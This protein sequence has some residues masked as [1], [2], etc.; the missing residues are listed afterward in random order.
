MNTLLENQK[1]LIHLFK[2]VNDES[3]EIQQIVTN[4]I[5]TN[6]LEIIFNKKYYL[7]TLNPEDSSQFNAILTELHLPLVYRSFRR[8]L[9]EAMDEMDLEK[10]VL[11]LS[12][13]HSPDVFTSDLQIHLDRIAQ[14][15]EQ[16]IP[17][18]GH[19]LSFVDHINQVLFSEYRFSGNTSD[20]YNPLNSFLHSVLQTG[21]GNPISLSVLYMLI[22]KRLHFPVY[23][24][25]MPAHFIL[26]FDNGEDEIFFDPFYRGKVYSRENC[27]NYLRQFDG[28]NPT[29]ILRGCG[30]QEILKRILRNLHLSYSSH[31]VDSAKIEQIE[32]LLSMMEAYF[33]DPNL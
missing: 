16:I 4:E 27:L 11:L 30:T 33:P 8:I 12:F 18:S 32:Q 25:C 28:Y 13:W 19:P 14:R 20:Y 2:L 22:C 15:I 26:K 21:K 1:N 29:D 7:K 24:V 9:D 17:M 10:S 5:L 31:T 3:E 23:G 6:S